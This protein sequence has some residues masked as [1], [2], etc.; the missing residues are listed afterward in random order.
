V[1]VAMEG[2]NPGG[3]LKF[4]RSGGTVS[5]ASGSTLQ[6]NPATT[7]ELDGVQDALSDGTNHV[8]VINNSTSSLKVLTGIKNAG[9]VSGVGNTTIAAGATFIATHIRQ[10]SLSIDGNVQIRPNSLVAGVSKLADVTVNSAGKFDLTDNK[11]IVSDPAGTFVGAAYDGVSGLVD[12]ARGSAGNALWDG[13]SG[14]TT[15]DTRAINNGDLVSIGVAKV[16]EVRT[17]ADTATTTFAGQAVLGSDTLVMATWGGDANL[18]G[19][20]N[21]DDYGRIDGNVGQSGSVFGWSKGDF[22]YD[23]KINIDDY[24]IIDGN[25]NRQGTP[26]ATSGSASSVALDGVSAVPEPASIGVIGLAM[27]G[28]LHRRRRPC[29]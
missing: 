13:T 3:A 23:G 21:I 10:N 26:F 8:N 15:S 1:V 14:I 12:A 4:A 27:V 16:S 9:G 5:V 25:I 22:N 29:Q 24:G 28:L 2:G 19:K 6:I 20:I 17:V 11:L 18:D 7:V